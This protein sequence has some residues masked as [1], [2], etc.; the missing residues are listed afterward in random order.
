MKL[1]KWLKK[2]LCCDSRKCNSDDYSYLLVNVRGKNTGF[3][4]SV[5][6]IYLMNDLG[7]N[8]GVF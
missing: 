2:W 6:G 4:S 8:I 3:I 7:E 5:E 1:L